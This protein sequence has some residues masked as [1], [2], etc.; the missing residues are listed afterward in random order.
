MR[1]VSLIPSASEIVAALGLQESL[2][3]RSHECDFPKGIAHLPV[4]TQ[5]K[6]D[7][8]GSSAEIDARVRSIVKDALSVY[9][10]PEGVLEELKPDVIVTQSQCEVCAVNLE[11]VEASIGQMG[12]S[13]PTII[14][15][16][17]NSLRDV[18]DDI[19]RVADGLGT[20]DA[21]SRLVN[22]MSSRF[23]AL[24]ERT[25]GLAVRSLLCVEWI[26]PLM[27]VGN[28]M[29]ELVE[30][31]GGR[32]VL[33]AR[34]DRGPG[35]SWQQVA[36]ADPD[37]ILVI[38]CGYEM[39]KSRRELGTLTSN[40]VWRS[41]KA[42]TAGQVAVADGNQYFNRPGPRL[43][44]S[45]EILAEFLHP[46]DFNFGHRGKAWVPFDPVS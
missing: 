8:E 31:A 33:G 32:E 15:L 10:I 36:A 22:S 3:G 24:R 26:E 5:P 2:V 46:D 11:E 38:P 29:P 20:A 27:A 37:A 44:E 14:S 7:P 40:P 41:L 1:I 6:F 34:D 45:A 35:I 4:C 42:V 17:P 30:I 25:K 23:A 9:Q 43:V 16:E 28:W 21:G 39:D 12:S 13:R 19:Q 18:L